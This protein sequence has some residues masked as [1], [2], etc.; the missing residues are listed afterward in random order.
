MV[1]LPSEAR[2]SGNSRPCVVGGVLHLGQGH[3]GFHRQGHAAFIQARIA[4]QALG[5]E[6]HFAMQRDL[7][8]DQSGIAALGARLACRSRCRCASMAETSAVVAGFSSSAVWPVIFA[9]PFFQM[10]RDLGR[11]FGKALAAPTASFSRSRID[12]GTLIWAR[13]RGAGGR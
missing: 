5:R 8:A 9:A 6:Q 1:Q 7:A 10:R 3:A 12:S 4:V 13:P 2:L 11:V